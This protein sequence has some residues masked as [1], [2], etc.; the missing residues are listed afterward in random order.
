MLRP[1]PAIQ[2]EEGY[3]LYASR[4][5]TRMPAIEQI[6]QPSISL[7]DLVLC[8]HDGRAG[9]WISGARKYVLGAFDN[10]PLLEQRL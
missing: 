10:L 2:L 1:I 9:P 4:G 6:G 3:A 5:D 8:R 7:I